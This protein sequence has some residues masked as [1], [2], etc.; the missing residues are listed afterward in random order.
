MDA[1]RDC[2][3]CGASFSRSGS[4]GPWPKRCSECATAATRERKAAYKAAHPE[5]CRESSRRYARAN[6]EKKRE[7]DRR[8]YQKD[9]QKHAAKRRSRYHADPEK[10]REAAR[11]YAAANREQ[12]RE[13]ARLWR[14]ANPER[15]REQRRV[16][17][18]VRRARER[19][20]PV[21]ELV[22]PLK[23]YERDGWKCHLCKKAINKRRKHP[24]PLSASVD[25]L[26]PLS[27]GGDH[28]YANVAA[29]HLVCNLRR[30]A[31]GPA[32]LRLLG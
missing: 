4:R 26:N 32:Q 20:A 24:D 12:A 2:P 25:H 1:T 19:N 23:V 16:N 29:A 17:R 9:P 7:R 13:R 30:N 18:A 27:L 11:K 8:L 6:P 5:M 3:D 31:T 22:V 15:V 21:V 10:G 14:E 28:S